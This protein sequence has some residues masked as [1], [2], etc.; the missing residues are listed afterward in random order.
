VILFH[1]LLQK[2]LLWHGV[3]F[4]TR[5]GGI[6]VPKSWKST[7][8]EGKTSFVQAPFCRSKT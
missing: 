3:D 4:T 2:S 7:W 6:L 8:D 1:N 5:C